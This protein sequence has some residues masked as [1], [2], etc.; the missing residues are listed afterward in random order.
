MES[1]TEDRHRQY[2]KQRNRVK[3]LTR[4]EKRLYEAS[5][6]EHA[7]DQP[8]MFWRYA[9]ANLKTKE[10]IGDL[11]V[12][13][14]VDEQGKQ[15]LTKDDG[16]KAEVLASFFSSVFTKEPE[17]PLN[18]MPQREVGDPYEQC[19]VTVEAVAKLLQQLDPCKAP[20]PDGV[21]PAVLKELSETLAIPLQRIYSTSLRT[22]QLP[23][24][25]KTATVTAIYKKGDKKRPSNYRPVSL[26]SVPCKVMEKLL[27]EWIVDHMKKNN[28]L[29][30]KQ[31]GFLAG[32]STTLQLLRVLDDWTSAMDRGNM[33]DVIYVDFMKAFDSVP[34]QR[35]LNRVES[36]GIPNPVL[37][38]V[39]S[40]LSGRTQRV[41]V[42]GN[43]SAEHE[44]T[45]GIPQGSVLG[46]TLFVLYINDLP[47]RVKDLFLFADDVKIYREITPENQAQDVELLQQDAHQLEDWVEESL[48]RIHPEKCKT[49]TISSTG[50][51][52][53]AVYTVTTNQHT[54]DINRVTE[55]KDLGITVDNSLSFDTHIDT[56]TNKANRMAGLIRRTFTHLDSKSFVLLFKAL[57][58]PVLEYGQAV[59]KPYLRKHI[60]KLESVQRRATKQVPGMGNLEYPDRLR[61]LNLPTLAYRRM[62]GDQIEIYKIISGRYDTSITGNI[63]TKST[64]TRTRGHPHKLH[65]AR[66]RLNTRQNHLNNRVVNTWNALSAPSLHAFENRL[67][68]YWLNHPLHWDPAAQEHTTLLRLHAKTREQ[69]E[70]LF[71]LPKCP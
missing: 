40:F 20:G 42:R 59:W 28:L 29:S 16:E 7:K 50:R 55:E 10:G 3:K 37:G 18:Q 12:E 6:A 65:K 41:S 39:R 35:L 69:G 11:N 31:Y 2:T 70:F 27:R 26:T 63:L 13:G 68:K 24:V 30:D 22:G 15:R 21:H 36:Y 32:R 23:S 45:S 64:N 54:M 67:D 4:S 17:G 48:M 61:R 66:C 57:V 14:E 53:G 47:D 33:V 71:C 44:V 1:R 60:N 34:H 49:M 5:L 8:K 25:W 51:S 56:V 38:W 62:R 9:K 52:S 19:P 58:R 46:P 43:Y